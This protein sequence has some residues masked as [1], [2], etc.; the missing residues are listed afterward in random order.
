MCANLSWLTPWYHPAPALYGAQSRYPVGCACPAGAIVWRFTG[1]K[2]AGAG[3][4]PIQFTRVAKLATSALYG[5]PCQVAMFISTDSEPDRFA[6]SLV[7]NLSAA[8]TRD[9]A[10]KRFLLLACA[11][12]FAVPRL[13][14]LTSF[15]DRDLIPARRLVAA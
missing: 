12:V 3:Q 14:S 15:I 6:G 9:V 1:P 4:L 7:G 13:W 2:R 8:L 11:Q 5:L 10:V